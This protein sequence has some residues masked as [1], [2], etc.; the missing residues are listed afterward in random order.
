M[1]E[2]VTCD[3][4]DCR[5]NQVEIVVAR[6]KVGM[7]AESGPVRFADQG[8]EVGCPPTRDCSTAN[9]VLEDDIARPDKRNEVTQLHLQV[10]KRPT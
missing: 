7:D 5:G 2:Y 9:D 3:Q 10:C 8:G 6:G 1:T 4:E